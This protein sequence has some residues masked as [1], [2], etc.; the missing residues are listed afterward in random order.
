ML[1]AKEENER[2]I[3]GRASSVAVG[4]ASSTTRADGIRFS[5]HLHTHIGGG[6]EA[7]ATSSPVSSN[8]MSSTKATSNNISIQSSNPILPSSSSPWTK[9]QSRNNVDQ[10]TDSNESTLYQTK[11]SESLLV[12]RVSSVE[13]AS[14][15]RD[16]KVSVQSLFA[17]VVL[18]GLWNGKE[19]ERVGSGFIADQ[20]R[21]LIVTAAH[22][23][24]DI[25]SS[26]SDPNS[27]SS[28]GKFY[29]GH[30]DAK[31]YIGTC[32][33]RG[34]NCSDDMMNSNNNAVF[35][36][37]AVI[38]A[39]DVGHVDAC[40]L[41]IITRLDDDV[42]ILD[43]GFV[44][45]ALQE[46]TETPVNR[47]IFKSTNE[48]I[49]LQQYNIQDFPEL[50]DSVRILG[51]NQDDILLNGSLGAIN[52]CADFTSGHVRQIWKKP[53]A[54]PTSTTMEISPIPVKRHD[55]R[56]WIVLHCNTIS[57]HSGG[58]CVNRQGEVVGILSYADENGFR[59]FVVPTKEWQSLL[60]TA[61][62]R[63]RI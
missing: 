8:Q 59:C 50:E 9:Q 56:M 11:S 36:Y 25:E 55:P 34:D 26:S 54:P 52:S 19:I 2:N 44:S 18:I 27:S 17:S 60:R 7:S 47:K 3:S 62:Y 10:N 42:P 53:V 28:F 37:R 38:V 5:Q 63:Q 29:F 58:P 21:G 61:K 48:L 16:D 41:R 45:S 1:P 40:V 14:A 33:P 12:H 23:V 43:N 6:F 13:T 22:T 35:R 57:G 30:E 15:S 51:H 4:V 20:S 39:A 49:E 31:I 46:Q 24:I 32:R